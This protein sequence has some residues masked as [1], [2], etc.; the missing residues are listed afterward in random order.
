[1]LVT[2]DG[3]VQWLDQNVGHLKQPYR[4]LSKIFQT[5]E[6][7]NFAACKAYFYEKDYPN[8]E[9]LGTPN[10]DLVQTYDPEH[11]IAIV[12]IFAD[13]KHVATR[14]LRTPGQLL[15]LPSGYKADFW[16]IEIEGV[17]RFKS[18]QMATSVKELKSV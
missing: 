18:F 5:P 17:V 14:E 10:H 9:L 7:V 3:K 6:P 13:G 15:R 1:M 4:W 2:F 11:Q 16:Q 12:R 8:P